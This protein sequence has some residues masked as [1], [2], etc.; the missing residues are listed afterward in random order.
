MSEIISTFDSSLLEFCDATVWIAQKLNG[1]SSNVVLDIETK[2]NALYPLAEKYD[3]SFRSSKV[4]ISDDLTLK[5]ESNSSTLWN[6]IAVIIR[7]EK[8]INRKIILVR[9]QLFATLLLSIHEA[10]NPSDE[11]KLR[12][13]KCYIIILKV[14]VDLKGSHKAFIQR[15][16]EHADKLLGILEEKFDNFDQEAAIQ[17]R[18]LKL[19]YFVLCLQITLKDGDLKMAKMYDARAEIEKNIDILN[20]PLLLEICRIVY[21]STLE[22]QVQSKDGNDPT[23]IKNSSDL[24]KNILRYLDLDIE[25]LQSHSNYMGIKFSVLTL[26]TKNLIVTLDSESFSNDCDKYIAILKSEFPKKVE[27]YTLAIEY[28]KKQNNPNSINDLIQENIMQMIVSVNTSENLDLVLRCINSLSENSTKSGN[29]CLDYLLFNKIDPQTDHNLL[30]KILITRFYTT[31]QSKSMTER[32]VIESLKEFNSQLERLITKDISISTV[33]AIITLIW[34]SGKNMEKTNNY[35]QAIDLYTIGLLDIFS[36]GYVDK[37]KLQRALINCYIKIDNYENAKYTYDLMSPQD[38]E[39]PLS[40]LLIL[41]VSI[42]EKNYDQSIKYLEAIQSAPYENSLETLIL[43]V[44]QCKE[45]TDLTVNALN[46]LFTKIENE[47]QSDAKVHA[48]TIPTLSLSRYTIQL[49]M[50]LSEDSGTDAFLYYFPTL[51]NLLQKSYSYLERIKLSNKLGIGSEEKSPTDIISINEIE[52]F[53]STAYNISVKCISEELSVN[54]LNIIQLASDFLRLLP[55]EDISFPK[56]FHFL[57]WNFRTEILK[58]VI[59][60]KESGLSSQGLENIQDKS[61][62]IIN[63][64]LLKKKDSHIQ[65]LLDTEK[66]EK[67]DQCIVDI[68]SISYETILKTNDR[69]KIMAI[70]NATEKYDDKRLE[71]YLITIPLSMSEFPKGILVDILETVIDR[72]ISNFSLPDEQ[73]ILWVKNL[74]SFKQTLEQSI[75]ISILER[76]YARIKRNN[77]TWKEIHESS[78]QNIEMISTLCWNQGVTAIM[79]DQKMLGVSYCEKSFQFAKLVNESFLGQLKQLWISLSSS[80]EIDE[81]LIE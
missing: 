27:C 10:L 22:L 16:Q 1:T 30:E 60:S 4:L 81:S 25:G 43:A 29:I 28:M 65:N 47:H 59:M 48:V 46:L 2:L 32:E 67:L 24:L 73:I 34:N 23:D 6:H 35:Q 20:S 76:L 49:I 5:L 44:S 21:N 64:I 12:S 57:F 79:K 77:S 36:K 3:R 69:N 72:N 78:N 56:R 51:I 9:S 40:L 41:K 58:L 15:I 8:D 14:I 45:N 52:W 39:S 42:E 54:P 18:K 26:L 71:T 17:F 13:F 31:T 11:R 19:E 63:E 50:K 66:I 33:S 70:V 75:N 74:L 62:Q 38:K 53:A 37:A 68:F 61:N 80:A 7:T 55:T